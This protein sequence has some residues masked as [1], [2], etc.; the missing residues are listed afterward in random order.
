MEVSVCALS[1][2]SGVP[3]VGLRRY[4][5]RT[6]LLKTGGFCGGLE[7]DKLQGRV[8][9]GVACVRFLIVFWQ[10]G[11]CKVFVAELRRQFSTKINS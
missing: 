8:W 6:L 11:I 7:K 10:F 4:I 2:N 3:S 9:F 1:T 5:R